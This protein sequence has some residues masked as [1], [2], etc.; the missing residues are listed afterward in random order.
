MLLRLCSRQWFPTVLF[1]PLNPKHQ[2]RASC[3]SVSKRNESNYAPRGNVYPDVC[4]VKS[5]WQN[6]FQVWKSKVK[7]E[8][9]YGQPTAAWNV[10]FFLTWDYSQQRTLCIMTGFKDQDVQEKY[11]WGLF[12]LTSWVHSVPSTRYYLLLTMASQRQSGGGG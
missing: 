3:S 5:K 12:W 4:T 9:A 8:T 1:D 2:N 11:A 6:E 7:A 10:F